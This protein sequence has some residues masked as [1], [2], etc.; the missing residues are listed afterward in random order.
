MTQAVAPAS[1]DVVGEAALLALAEGRP[2]PDWLAK[3]H[4]ESLARF[5]D[6]GLPTV[7]DEAWKYT[8]LNTLRHDAWQAP[9]LDTNVR[10]VRDT[11]LTADV[12]L[13][14]VNGRLHP[15]LCRLPKVPGLNPERH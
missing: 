7:R 8:N 2:S 10:G 9:A 5:R 12:R 4:D 1:E 13:V 6:R 15:E 11:E 3:L 14:F